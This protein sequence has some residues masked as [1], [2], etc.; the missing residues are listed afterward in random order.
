MRDDFLDKY[1][2][3]ERNGAATKIIQE[4]A[5]KHAAVDAAIGLAGFLPIP[6]AAAMSILASLTAQIPLYKLLARKLSIVYELPQDQFSKA[7][8]N[9]N[10]ALDSGITVATDVGT[11]LAMQFG[12]DFLTD[13]IGELLG[14]IGIGI[15]VSFIPILGGFVSMGLDVAIAVTMTWRVG[16]M[17][18]MYHQNGRRW[19]DSREETFSRASRLTGGVSPSNEGRVDLNE[20]PD[21]NP[22]IRKVLLEQAMSAVKN[23]RKFR[24][25]A[26]DKEI[27]DFLRDK[28]V[29]TDIRREAI[30]KA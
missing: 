18:S 21:K 29:P 11:D 8:V 10:M 2:S 20:I 24:S 3:R 5:M 25:D 1:P 4:F 27:D 23:L 30:R 22:E 7:M 15:G 28:G 13:V 16:I 12:S 6:G 17:V 26:T 9:G 19:I 14:E